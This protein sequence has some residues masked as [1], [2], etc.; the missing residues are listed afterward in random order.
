MH[1]VCHDVFATRRFAQAA[2]LCA[3]FFFF[4][5]FDMFCEMREAAQ[6]ARSAAPSFAMP[7]PIC[8]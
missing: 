8:F 5:H 7:L 2:P 3:G 4:F 1:A 6:P